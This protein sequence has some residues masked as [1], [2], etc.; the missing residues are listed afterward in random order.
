MDDTEGM[1]LVYIMTAILGGCGIMAKCIQTAERDTRHNFCQN[2]VVQVIGS[3]DG[4][5]YCS[6]QF[7]D[8]T[9]GEMVRPMVGQLCR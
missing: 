4:Y 3:C 5:G 7:T 6:V 9:Y 1:I 2:K 8:G